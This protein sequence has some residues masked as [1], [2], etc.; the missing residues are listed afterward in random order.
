MTEKPACQEHT[1]PRSH[2][3]I[4]YPCQKVKSG[5]NAQVSIYGGK[6]ESGVVIDRKNIIKQNDKS[7][8]YVA[9]G[10]TAQARQVSTG[11]LLG[12][13]V[14][15]T[16]GLNPGD[17]IITEGQLLLKDGSKIRVVN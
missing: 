6:G 2:P 9:K 4:Q 7:L 12:L 16:A 3:I 14:E 8:V 11:K 13:D 5:V 10:E 1:S 17:V 15:I